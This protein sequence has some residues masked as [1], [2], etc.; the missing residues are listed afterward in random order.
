MVEAIVLYLA[1]ERHNEGYNGIFGDSS[2]DVEV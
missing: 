2:S 1:A